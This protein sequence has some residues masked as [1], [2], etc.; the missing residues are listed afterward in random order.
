MGILLFV[1]EVLCCGFFIDIVFMGFFWLGVFSFLRDL[2]CCNFL[3]GGMGLFCLCVMVILMKVWLG[4]VDCMVSFKVFIVV[5]FVKFIK[6]LL[7]I[8]RSWLFGYRWLFLVVVFFG[9]IDLIKM[10][11]FWG[12]LWFCLDVVC[13]LFFIF[14]F[15]FVVLDRFR[16][17]LNV[18]IWR[19]FFLKWCK[20]FL[21]ILKG[22]ID[23]NI[24]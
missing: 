23:G 19:F 13:D 24:W 8:W 18:S 20:L 5:W 22:I 6:D 2:F 7:F 21:L 15:R 10:F 17:I 1:F 12:L 3:G 16:G 11:L 14:M 4:F 9:I